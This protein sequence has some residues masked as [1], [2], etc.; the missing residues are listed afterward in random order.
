[1]RILVTGQNGQVARAL[2]GLK[3][4]GLAVTAIGR[5][6]LNILDP[7]SIAAAISATGP[8]MLVNAAAYTAVDAAETDETAAFRLNRDG[9]ANAA[10]AAAEA[11]L[12]IVQL[13]TDY[14]FSGDKPE[15]Y[16]E[17][18]APAPASVY[19]RSKL[20]GERAVIEANRQHIVLRTAWVYSGFGKNFLK[21]MLRLA[22][23]HDTVRI[24]ADQ[25]G[26]PT[27]AADIADAIAA[28]ARGIGSAGERK[29]WGTYHLVSG[30]TANWAEFAAEIFACS[31]RLGGPSARIEA[32][33]TADYP[34]LARRPANS[35]LNTAKFVS[36]FGW[37][38]PHWKEGTRRCV[39]SLLLNEGG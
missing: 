19:G 1:M 7:S 2:Q 28:V 16:T 5:P 27:A 14:V 10:R 38:P 21:T 17:A 26:T 12:P 13:S 22:A 6:G 11:G 15:P 33:A 31:A 24:V 25:F 20:A 39:E 34:T 23:Q 3:A 29:P 30:G 8:D 35:R 4:D 32:I 18:D 9:A 36:T 37:L